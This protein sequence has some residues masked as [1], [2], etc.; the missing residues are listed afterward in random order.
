M[1]ELNGEVWVMN[2]MGKQ[3]ILAIHITSPFIEITQT[4]PTPHFDE[5]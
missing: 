5:S 3:L 4:L 2:R 1:R